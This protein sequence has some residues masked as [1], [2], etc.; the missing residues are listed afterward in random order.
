MTRASLGPGI[1]IDVPQLI[2]SRLLVQANSGGGKS[3]T[4]RRLCEQTYGRCQH[5]IIDPDG[6]HKYKRLAGFA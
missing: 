6:I 2:K 1:D 5:I 3:F 4:L